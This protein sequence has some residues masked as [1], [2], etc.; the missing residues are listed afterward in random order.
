[1]LAHDGR[2]ILL[3][4]ND[5]RL[6]SVRESHASF[7]ALR[8]PLLIPYV[9]FGWHY[10]IPLG[11]DS[12][13]DLFSTDVAVKQA[14]L[15]DPR[16][17]SSHHRAPLSSLQTRTVHLMTYLPPFPA[18]FGLGRGGSFKVSCDQFHA[19]HVHVQ[20]DFS[21]L[22]WAGNL[23]QEY[24]VDASAVSEQA[25]LQWVRANQ[26]DLR[27]DLYNGVMDALMTGEDLASIGRR[28][29][30]PS[31]FTGGPRWWQQRYHDAI[32]LV[33]VYTSPTSSSHSHA[34]LSGRRS[35]LRSILGKSQ[36]IGRTSSCAFSFSS[37]SG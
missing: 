2:D 35:L 32:S 30:L 10:Y 8:F 12:P 6:R 28:I 14:A 33:R 20:P 17:E 24:L 36:R 5:G 16:S 37:S 34:T 7:L 19:F 4:Y 3:Y 31:S 26:T 13:R 22:F 1:M 9:H 25:D 21:T 27:A 29:V 11:R 23:L 18:V 15:E